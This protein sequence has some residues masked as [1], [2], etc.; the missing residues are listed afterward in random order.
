MSRVVHL[1]SAHRLSDTRI[2]E[3]ECRS[4]AEAGHEVHLVGPGERAGVE[5]GVHVHVVAAP[6]NRLE[7][8]VVTP[9]RLYRAAR[10]LDPDLVHLHDPEV[11]PVGA[12]LAGRGHR[13]VWDAHESL[14][15]QLAGRRWMPRPLRGPAGRALGRLERR[16]TRRFAGAVGATPDITAGLEVEPRAT[17]QNLPLAREFAA[18]PPPIERRPATV[19]YVGD[20]TVARGAKEMVE[21][22]ALLPEGARLALAGRMSEPD[23]RAALARRPGWSRVDELGWL[24]RAGVRSLLDRARVGLVVL[25][26]VPNYLRARPVKLFEYL[27]AGVPAVA[28]DLPAWRDLVGDRCLYVDP[29]DPTAIAEA[30]TWLIEHPGDAAELAERGRAHVLREMSWTS[31]EARLLALY[32][33]VLARPAPVLVGSAP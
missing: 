17:V 31:E 11:L 20:L 10:R 32:D 3:K 7:R 27:A 14:A 2:F 33:R 13:V 15:L 21:A 29:L 8:A 1:T 25:H 28:S 24:D 6:R 18:E 22:A 19:A 5:H 26:P 9:W 16:A 30:T 12:R 23:L 4:L